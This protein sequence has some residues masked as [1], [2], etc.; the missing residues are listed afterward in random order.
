M[1]KYSISRQIL[2]KCQQPNVRQTNKIHET[3]IIFFLIVQKTRKEEN[4]KI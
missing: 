3:K 4:K 1:F 2:F